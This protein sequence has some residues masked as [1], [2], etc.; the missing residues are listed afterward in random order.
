M[1]EDSIDRAPHSNRDTITAPALQQ[2]RIP[3]GLRDGWR[4]M[5]PTQKEYT[6]LD[7]QAQSRLDRIY[8]TNGVIKNATNWEIQETL[9]PTDHKMISVQVIDRKSPYIGKGR[10]TIPP[11]ILEDRNLQLEIQI[12]GQELERKLLTGQRTEQSNPQTL[13]QT[14]KEQI[15]IAAKERTKNKIPKITQQIES[16]EA[17]IKQ[18]Q[19]DPNYAEDQ[20]A[21]SLSREIHERIKFLTKEKAK[22]NSDKIAARYRIEG[23]MNSKYWSQINKEKRPRDI[24]F[25]LKNPEDMNREMNRSDKMAKI[26]RD[27]YENLQ[28]DGLNINGEEREATMTNLLNNIQAKPTVQQTES[29]RA[30]IQRTEVDEIITK[31][32]NGKATGLDGIPYELWKMLNQQYK[33]AKKSKKNAF[34]VVGTLTKVYNDIEKHGVDP[35]TNFSEGWICPIYKKKDNT[36]ITNYRPITLLNSDYK[37]L[38]KCI[39]TRL[40]TIAPTIIHPNQAG[41]VP[42]R[43]IADQVRLLK[44]IINNAEV[45]E[46][47]G[48][49]IALDQE[50][51]YDRFRHDYLWRVLG[52]FRIPEELVQTIRN[53]YEN[54]KSVVIINGVKSEPF[55]ITRG[56]RQGDAMSCPLSI[57]A[58]KPLVE[59]LRVSN[60][61]GIEIPGVI[62]K[63]I[64]TLFADDTTVYLSEEDKLED[65][66]RI[67]DQ[68]CLAAG[69]K[70]NRE[71]TEIIP[72]G[73]SEFRTNLIQS[74]KIGQ[75]QDRI[76]D[77]IHIAKDGEAIRS[78]GAWIGNGIDQHAPWTATLDKIAKA[79]ARRDDAIPHN[80]PRYAGRHRKI[81]DEDDIG[82]HLGRKTTSD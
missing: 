67:L 14:F 2:F 75:Q 60:L 35:K 70:F 17:K 63:I 69:S 4:E 12:M 10:W 44:L 38:T 18:V 29:L 58:I 61:K 3:M 20:D 51:A 34:D 11:Y 62:E 55:D 36:E 43:S 56:V 53:L 24:I 59:A 46:E 22:S 50:K 57:M 21:Q 73:T 65:L 82:L 78:L 49:I 68:W 74:R 80:R 1:V 28:L 81:P 8:A 23:E 79:L 76:P 40:L 13:F 54:A 77:S 48:V 7:F 37:I 25:A 39:A 15:R 47:N 32:E 27:F 42:G 72:I 19:Q 33:N 9:I 6:F 5:N 45:T 30:G 64:T 41:F 26:A 66:T 16:L 71:K 31:V 52:A